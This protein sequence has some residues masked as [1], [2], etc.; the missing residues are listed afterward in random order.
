MSSL[1]YLQSVVSATHGGPA[2]YEVPSNLAPGE[3]AALKT[4]ITRMQRV[5]AGNN[6]LVLPSGA[7]VWE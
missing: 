6:E 3:R 5:R 1:E 4:W 7:L 2:V